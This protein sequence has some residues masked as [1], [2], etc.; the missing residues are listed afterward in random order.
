M[1][2]VWQ[3][4]PTFYFGD[5]IGNDC[6]AISRFLT[7]EGIEN[8]IAAKVIHPKMEKYAVTFEEAKEKI[9]DDD[10]I[11]YHLSV[12][13]E[14]NDWFAALSNKKGVIYHNITP[15][16]FFKT[17]SV[18]HIA[19]T[20]LGR[21]QMTKM[22]G[23]VDFAIADSAYNAAELTKL[24]FP[25]PS[26]VPILMPFDDY[27][28][29][30]DAETVRK[31]SDGKKNILFVG[32]VAPNKCQEDIIAVFSEL[33]KH[34][35]V[36]AR[37][38][39]AGSYG[40]M[41][42]YKERLDKYVKQLSLSDDVIFTGHISFAEILAFYKTAHAFVIMSEHEGFCVPVVEAYL[43][44]VPVLAC[45]YGAIGETMG[46]AGVLLSSQKDPAKAASVL[47]EMLNDEK[48]RAEQKE[49]MKE[50]LT[51][52]DTKVVEDRLREVLLP[53]VKD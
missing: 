49:K 14:M 1:R 32:R 44:G 24:G 26:V 30:P 18:A 13:D 35:G 11:L 20:Q 6:L 38:I 3:I 41:E 46:G 2:K 27:K 51:R 42:E 12:G 8:G 29:E 34:Y 28:Q 5:A 25:T 39:L 47:L 22:A 4:L 36:N 9:Q 10:L 33:K 23:S 7:D 53:W 37:L 40:G 21:R 16:R 19:V 48:W 15:Y 17:Y 52:F 31:M 50:A 45:D 43:F